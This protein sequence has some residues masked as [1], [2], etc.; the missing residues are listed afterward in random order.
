MMQR[1]RSIGGNVL[2]HAVG[3]IF[4]FSEMLNA[5]YRPASTLAEEAAETCLVSFCA[6]TRFRMKY[7][8]HD[9]RVMHLCPNI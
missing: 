4:P 2:A 7:L 3:F 8:R 9:T 6:T 5:R 1:W